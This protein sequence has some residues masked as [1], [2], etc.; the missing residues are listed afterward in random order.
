L[1]CYK[2]VVFEDNNISL[3]VTTVQNNNENK[4]IEY[5]G[6]TFIENVPVPV[7]YYDNIE[8]QSS[9]NTLLLGSE[10]ISLND[11]EINIH[12]LITN[13]FSG[14]QENNNLDNCAEIN[15]NSYNIKR[16]QNV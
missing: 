15:Y 7:P 10:I 13:N 11:L 1:Y 6:N 4:S 9:E 2:Q 8:I 16:N 12:E 3:E 5:D 14:V